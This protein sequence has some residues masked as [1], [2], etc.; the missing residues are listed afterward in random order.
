M[1]KIDGIKTKVLIHWLPSNIIEDD[2]MLVNTTIVFGM[3]KKSYYFFLLKGI[4]LGFIF[5]YQL[6]SGK[7]CG[8]IYKVYYF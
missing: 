6:L 4:T 5:N 1:K 2:N 3:I 8:K 7:H